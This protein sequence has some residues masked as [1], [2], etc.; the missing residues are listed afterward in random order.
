MA[1]A[2]ESTFPIVDLLLSKREKGEYVKIV[3]PMVRYSK[4]PFR[5]LCRKWGADIAFTPM[6]IAEGFNR[7]E[8][9]RDSE[10][11]TCE[12]DKPLV[13][14]FA[15][16]CAYEFSVAARTCEEFVDAVDLNCGCP[17]KWA[18]REKIGAFLSAKPE[19]VYDI[20]KTARSTIR[21]P[22]SIKIRIHKDF[23]KTLDLLRRAEDAGIS[24]ISVH[25]RTLEERSSVPVHLDALKKI[26]EHARVPVFA[27][28]DMFL[29]QD[30]DNIVAQTG[31][32]GVMSARGIMANPALFAGFDHVPLEC[33][34]DF[35]MLNICYGTSAKFTIFH[36]HLLF[37]ISRY[38]SRED[39][40]HFTDLQSMA[41]IIDF[42]VSR[43]LLED[44]SDLCELD[45]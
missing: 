18:V 40:R 16:S 27:N 33:V 1:F 26:K 37:M 22:V 4:L 36:N 21:K 38:L 29:P 30:L 8:S 7:S 3:A 44:T 12:Q 11:S 43:G 45:V 14:Q 15:A 17:Q 24:W 23:E 31:V 10:F 5:L 6:I 13:V 25:G 32:D 39:R 42:F 20:V 28:G 34:I 41:G 19:T 35:L 9:A 2:G